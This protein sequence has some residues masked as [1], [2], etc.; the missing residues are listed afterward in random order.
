MSSEMIKWPHLPKL[1]SFKD[2][3]NKL[4][5]S[6]R[7]KG[8][9]TRTERTDW[10][11]PLDVLETDENI[12]VKVEIPG[13]EPKDIDISISG[14]TLTIKGEKKA[15]KEETGKN[16]H[17]VERSYG[18]FSGSIVLP[19]SVKFEHAKAEYKKGILEITLP[20]SVKSEV[21]KIPVKVS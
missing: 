4:F 6:I 7:K 9:T 13:V 18:N 2:E 11:P 8:V 10:T 3:M 16:Y 12:L 14:N 17:F 21:K 20:K 15:E 5:D 1:G 19:T